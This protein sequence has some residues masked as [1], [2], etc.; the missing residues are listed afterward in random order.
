MNGKYNQSPQDTYIVHAHVRH[1]T[2]LQLL[3]RTQQLH[4]AYI[5]AYRAQYTQWMPSSTY[6]TLKEDHHKLNSTVNGVLS[7]TSGFQQRIQSYACHKVLHWQ[8]FKKLKHLRKAHLSNSAFSLN[9][10]YQLYIMTSG[11]NLGKDKMKK[12]HSTVVKQT[13]ASSSC[14]LSSNSQKCY[15]VQDPLL[16]VIYTLPPLKLL[17]PFKLYTL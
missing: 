6:V 16:Q 15:I 1:L 2:S 9:F 13:L 11:N 14:F 10:K 12:H 17:K 7:L 5:M 8:Q 4:M 3:Y